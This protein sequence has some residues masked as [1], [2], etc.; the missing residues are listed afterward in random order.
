MS[1]I[2]GLIIQSRLDYIENLTQGNIF[3]KV[4]RKLSEPV[5]QAFGEQVF[6]TNLYPFTYLKELDLAIGEA[7]DLSLESIFTDIG[8]KSANLLLDRYFSNYVQGENPQG[9]LS[10]IEKLYSFLW[11]FGSYRY[12]KINDLSAELKFDFDEDIHKP[13]CWYLQSFLQRGVEL[14]GGAKVH[15]REKMC[16]AED[17]ESCIY[18][19]EWKKQK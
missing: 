2:R 15:L 13:Y 19:I 14:C 7:M 6:L 17:G 18:Q 11:N 9:F 16:E 10:Q 8:V 5:R 3:E 4:K 12:R 1:E